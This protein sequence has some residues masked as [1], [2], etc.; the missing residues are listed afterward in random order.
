[1][2]QCRETCDTSDESKKMIM[3]GSHKLGRTRR[4]L[5]L[6]VNAILF[7]VVAIWKLPWPISYAQGGLDPSWLIGIN[8]AFLRNLQFGTELVFTY[9]PLGFL[10]FPGLIDYS[11][12]ML[13][14][15]FTLFSHFMLFASTFLFVACTTSTTGSVTKLAGS[16][17][18]LLI[19]VMLAPSGAGHEVILSVL[20]LAYILFS[21]RLR[22]HRADLQSHLA[23]LLGLPL[24]IVSLI[25]FNYFLDSISLLI[26]VALICGIWMR[27]E[28]KLCIGI[29]AVYVGS[30]EVLWIISRQKFFGMLDYVAHG[31][32]VALGYNAA[33]GVEG[34][35]WQVYVG[36]MLMTLIPI[37]LVY[38]SA[39]RKREVSLFLILALP[40]L[41]EAFKYGY[42]R[43]D[44]HVL[45]FMST[46]AL[47]AGL[48]NILILKDICV[49]PG[50]I[51]HIVPLLT[52][53]ALFALIAVSGLAYPWL[54]RDNLMVKVSGYDQ[55][56]TLLVDNGRAESAIEQS[57]NSIRAQYRVDHEVIDAIGTSTVD[58]L[59]WDIALLW[60]Y[61][62]N[63]SPRP[64]LQSY[65]AYTREL[66]HLDSMHFAAGSRPEYLLYAYESI[67]GRYP[68]FDEP[69]TFRTILFGYEYAGRTGEFLLL[70]RKIFQGY[71]T[72]QE[73][74]SF[75]GE[76]G[77]FIPVPRF[78]S[79]YLFGNVTVSYSILGA[80]R[81][82]LYKPSP[83][84][85]Q[86]KFTDGRY[87]QRFR[88]IESTAGNG[89][90]LSQY[91][92]SLD[93][94]SLVFK[95][96]VSRDIQGM[97]IQGDSLCYNKEISVAFYGVSSNVSQIIELRHP[98]RATILPEQP[99]EGV[100]II[101]GDSRSQRT[102]V[103]LKV[104]N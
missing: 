50:T 72:A 63:W 80:I 9:G 55:A 4:N 91:V 51:T 28:L 104:H 47:I 84:Y 31:L 61:N 76:L 16:T 92:G 99:F 60:S 24:A 64:V 77:S 1:M 96:Y 100:R 17:S 22:R 74:G 90:F 101:N 7:G 43:H 30:L 36:I 54:M 53:L 3:T 40:I 57:K 33:M 27:R 87:S 94:L 98:V 69:E 32:Q 95:G 2:N 44:L 29:L 45:Y 38:Y 82:A 86:F 58:V 21:L 66:D 37:T 85:M 97:I 6:V 88:F 52:P 5:V 73:L 71:G 75:K 56:M 12:W 20:L 48:L 78:E 65:S 26:F 89:L 93:D 67:D 102:F 79:G 59:P 81:S 11:L 13:S 103:H 15:L 39:R 70:R 34:I 46:F 19:F 10:E 62:L 25:K 18:L 83:L 49:D 42:V 14:F 68:I 35:V 41:F 8:W 23:L